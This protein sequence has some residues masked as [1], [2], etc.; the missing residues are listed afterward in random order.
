MPMNEVIL[1]RR[2][3]LGMTQEQLAERLGVTAPAVNK[4]EKGATCPDLMLLSPL[5]RLL[6]VDLNEL[7]CFHAASNARGSRRALPSPARACA[8]TRA[9]RSSPNN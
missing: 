1:S 7:L 6:G 9:A 5:A 8:N 3:A 2:R 4:W